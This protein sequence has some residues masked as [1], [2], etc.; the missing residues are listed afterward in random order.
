[1]RLLPGSDTRRIFSIPEVI[2]IARLLQPRPL[3]GALA[4]LL[5]LLPSNKS[6]GVRRSG[7]WEEKVPCSAGNYSGAFQTSF[8][9]KQ[10][11]PPSSKI[12]AV[13][14]ENPNRRKIRKEEG[15]KNLSESFEEKSSEEDPFPHR[16]FWATSISPVTM[17]EAPPLGELV[18]SIV[19]NLPP[20]VAQIPDHRAAIT[21]QISGDD[22]KPVFFL[23]RDDP[24]SADAFALFPTLP[25]AHNSHRLC[26]GIG[27]GHLPQVP[28]LHSASG[29]LGGFRRRLPFRQSQRFAV[30]SRSALA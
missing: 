15:R 12:T 9:S 8:G 24:S 6:A 20:Q 14:E 19:F 28:N 4:G 22:P 25:H 11:E 21:L 26:I 1:M 13:A 18:E 17:G 10:R 3:T 29:A 27:E 2:F 30:K 23:V 7:S 16:R 5:T